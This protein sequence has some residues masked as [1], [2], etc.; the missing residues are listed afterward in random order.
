MPAKTEVYETQRFR[1]YGRDRVV[2]DAAISTPNIKYGDYFIISQRYVFTVNE[3]DENKTH[4]D[5]SLAIKWVKKTWF[6]KIIT[7]KATSEAEQG[8]AMW[9]S[10]L[11]EI[12]LPKISKQEMLIKQI[13]KKDLLPSPRRRVIDKKVIDYFHAPMIQRSRRDVIVDDWLR[14]CG[15]LLVDVLK[16]VCRKSSWTHL[17]N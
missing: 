3:R 8:V 11:H 12:F 9:C 15:E 17:D 2:V 16:V 10:K 13:S 7:S 6:E 4:M 1:F 14:P 5:C